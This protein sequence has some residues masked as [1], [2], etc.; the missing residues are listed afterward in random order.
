MYSRRPIC[1]L[2]LIHILSTHG[3]FSLPLFFFPYSLVVHFPS[4]FDLP[5]KK[6]HLDTYP[7]Y[8]IY[9]YYLWCPHP[10]TS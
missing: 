3:E 6:N 7:S 2:T 4:S 9:L 10:L 1:L 8:L 5:I